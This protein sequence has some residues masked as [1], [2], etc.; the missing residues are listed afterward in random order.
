MPCVHFLL[1]LHTI[2]NLCSAP[3]R[4][5]V[6]A[7]WGAYTYRQRCLALN[8]KSANALKDPVGPAVAVSMMT[9]VALIN[10][11]MGIRKYMSQQS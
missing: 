1:A 9:V 2:T 6:Q 5:C 10:S 3:A 4:W 11:Y 8:E 7:S